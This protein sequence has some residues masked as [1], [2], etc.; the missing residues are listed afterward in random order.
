MK[1]TESIE[2]N[3]EESLADE[4]FS[5]GTEERKKHFIGF[6]THCVNAPGCPEMN[7]TA[8]FATLA[9]LALDWP[10]DEDESW[11]V[12]TGLA[13][14]FFKEALRNGEINPNEMIESIGN[15]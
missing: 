15:A 5:H 11:C 13:A 4:I 8:T 6:M 2:A 3:W 7:A 1:Q 10:G 12:L 14:Y 9:I